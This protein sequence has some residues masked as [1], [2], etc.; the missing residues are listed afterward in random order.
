MAVFAVIAGG[1]TAG[2]ADPVGGCC[3]CPSAGEVGDCVEATLVECEALTD[4]LTEMLEE[5]LIPQT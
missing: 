2:R 1:S 4:P 5:F 3:L